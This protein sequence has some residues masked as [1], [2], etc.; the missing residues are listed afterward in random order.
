MQK[1]FGFWLINSNFIIQTVLCYFKIR[2][3]TTNAF[4]VHLKIIIL[5]VQTKKTQKYFGL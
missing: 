3:K 2:K 1:T 4:T 5:A